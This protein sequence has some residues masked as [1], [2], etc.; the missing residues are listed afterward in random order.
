[1]KGKSVVV[2]GGGMLDSDALSP[3]LINRLKLPSRINHSIQHRDTWLGGVGGWG[4]LYQGQDKEIKL[5][6]VEVGGCG[7]LSIY[8]M[9]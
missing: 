8:S 4:G 1:M 2:E 7:G 5:C 9:N 6:I 3:H